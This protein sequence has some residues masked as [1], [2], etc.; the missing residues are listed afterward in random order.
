MKKSDPY[1]EIIRKIVNSIGDQ[2][3][4]TVMRSYI[5]EEIDR[6]DDSISIQKEWLAIHPKEKYSKTLLKNSKLIKNKLLGCFHL[7]N[8]L[9]AK[10][11]EADKLIKACR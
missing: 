7:L 5:Q 8:Q 6:T 10:A 11:I 1:F 9:E 2:V 3:L 4:L